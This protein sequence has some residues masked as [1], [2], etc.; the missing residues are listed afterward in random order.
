MLHVTLEHVPLFT[1]HP[2]EHQVTPFRTVLPVLLVT[3]RVRPRLS[4][5]LTFAFSAV[6]FP[7][8]QQSQRSRDFRHIE[9]L[10]TARHFPTGSTCRVSFA[11][12]T[13]AER[14][15]APISRTVSSSA[16]R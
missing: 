11:T 15:D 14:G 8:L 12:V 3:V 9:H 13:F 5:T 16:E 10:A 6:P 1:R 4:V 2:H 7:V